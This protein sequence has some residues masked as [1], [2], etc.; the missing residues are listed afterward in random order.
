MKTSINIVWVKSDL[1]SDPEKEHKD[2]L[3]EEGLKRAYEQ[4][5]ACLSCLR[6]I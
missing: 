5:K 6:A 1:V 3:I 2:S 4:I